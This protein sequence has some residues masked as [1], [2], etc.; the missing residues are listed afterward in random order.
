MPRDIVVFD[1]ETIPDA[2][3]VTGDEFPKTLFCQ[4]V[5]ISFLAAHLEPSDGGP[6]FAVDEL[7]TGGE[8]SWPEAQLVRGFFQYIEK[9]KPRLV[10][11][12]GRGFDLPLLKY[13]ALRHEATAP[14]FAVGE[15]R[16]E[17]YGYRYQVDYHFDLMDALT[18]F[19]A[20]RAAGLKDVS[21]L[22][23]IP[24]K[25]GVDGSQVKEMVETGR[26][27]EVRDYC[28]TDVL[29]TYLIFLRF[30]LFRGELSPKGYELSVANLR[31][32]LTAERL[33]RPHLGAF[34]DQWTQLSP[35]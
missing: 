28:E 27:S 5:A 18:D 10:T 29:S 3:H 13:R 4:I 12:N 32:Y 16:F 19:G 30:A 11:F 33:L 26:L 14:W 15:G 6:F 35:P 9:K 22:L 17:S 25:L 7:R 20:S 34:L 21:A 8:V 2:A 23:G 24:S 1:T 31:S